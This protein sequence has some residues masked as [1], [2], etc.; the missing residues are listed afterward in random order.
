M[1][2]EKPAGEW[3]AKSIAEATIGEAEWRAQLVKAPDGSK[4]LG[5]RKFVTLR[6]GQ[7]RSTSQGFL[8]KHTSN[9]AARVQLK[10]I[11]SLI[12]ALLQSDEL[13]GD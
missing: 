9:K 1:S 2:R 12:D 6:S 5:V 8:L 11:R 10:R 13:A 4:M 3:K 7:E